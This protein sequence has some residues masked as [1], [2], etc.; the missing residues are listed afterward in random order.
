MAFCPKCGSQV[1]EGAQ[2]CATCGTAFA[3]APAPNAAPAY[4]PAPQYAPAPA[5]APA[6]KKVLPPEVANNRWMAI[7]CY[8]EILLIFPAILKRDNEFVAYHINQG[9]ALML[10]GVAGLICAIVPFLGWLVCAVV[11]VFSIVCIIMG[12]I[13]AAKGEMAPLPLIGKL[14]IYSL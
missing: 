12:I 11:E 14:K 3:A 7:L 6:P 8:L 2:F 10:L 1:P 13:H 5:P 9:L 4:N